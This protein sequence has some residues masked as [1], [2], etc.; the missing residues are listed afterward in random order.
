MFTFTRLPTSTSLPSP[1]ARQN[2]S[3]TGQT[4]EQI[5][6]R[7][8]DLSF[9]LIV[10]ILNLIEI[11]LISKLKR[12]K[13]I[14][15]ICILSLCITDFLFGLSNSVVSAV[16]LSQNAQNDEILEITYTTYFYF[17]LNSI[18]HL[19]LITF[20]RVWLVYKPLKHRIHVTRSRMCKLLA[21][22]W[23][24]STVIAIALFVSDELTETFTKSVEMTSYVNTTVSGVAGIKSSYSVQAIKRIQMEQQ[25][26][27]I[28]QLVLSV[29]II[30]ADVFLISSYSFIIILLKRKKKIASNQE[31]N[32]ENKVSLICALIAATFVIFTLPYA[33]ARLTVG[34][35]PLW[36]NLILVSNS[37][38]NSIIYFF[39][40]K[41]ENYLEKRDRT[42]V[43]M[44]VTGSTTPL[45]TP[46]THAKNLKD[47]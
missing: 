43:T 26:P 42:Q 30:I 14:Y 5:L 1:T 34:H 19:S 12:Q 9:G 25:Y 33:V 23:I 35:T 4:D 2:T 36:A 32:M 46:M 47:N 20:D 22:T 3:P 7:S 31:G 11:I 28:M 45:R 24:I 38:L 21:I 18:L 39:R 40:G 15:E 16:Y 10:V 8:I 29:F 13:K 27:S 37:G 17:V 6:K 44:N 41:C